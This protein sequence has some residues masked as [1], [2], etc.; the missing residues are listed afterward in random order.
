MHW[1]TSRHLLTGFVA[2]GVAAVSTAAAAG[3]PGPR[4]ACELMLRPDAEAAVGQALPQTTENAVLRMCDYNTSDFA[5]GASLTVGTWEAV[6]TAA[7][8][9]RAVPVSV[10]GV[11]DEAL[12]LN[13]SNGS[14]LYVRVKNEGFLLVLHGPKIDRLPDRGLAKETVL[15]LSIVARFGR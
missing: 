9:G 12:N 8:S 14:L 1:S 3:T 5:A 4:G 6:R 11:G 15:A 2:L 10:S 7:T 13:G